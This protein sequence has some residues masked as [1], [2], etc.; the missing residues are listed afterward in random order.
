MNDRWGNHEKIGSS[1]IFETLHSRLTVQL[2]ATS[3]ADLM[4]CNKYERVSA[5][6]ENERHGEIS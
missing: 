5:L 4:T 1:A 6:M 3:R 2:I